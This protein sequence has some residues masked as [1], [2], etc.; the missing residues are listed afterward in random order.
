M[1]FCLLRLTLLI[2]NRL[3]KS[4]GTEFSMEK[5]LIGR[6]V[7]GTLFAWTLMFIYV[8]GYNCIATHQCDCNCHDQEYAFPIEAF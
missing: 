1:Y 8:N 7:K 3:C 5:G 2:Y 6:K 4:N